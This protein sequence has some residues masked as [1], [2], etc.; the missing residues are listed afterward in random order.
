[1]FFNYPNFEPEFG[2]L[3]QKIRDE[4]I[5]DNIQNN[6]MPRESKEIKKIT[7]LIASNNSSDKLYFWQLYSILGELPIKN[8]ITVFYKRVLND[9]KNPWF[10]DEFIE[11]GNLEYHVKGQMNFWID[12]MGGGKKYYKTERVLYLKHQQVNEIMTQR[13]AD[14]WMKHMVNSLYE[15]NLCRSDD[16][17]IIPCIS[18]FLYY[19]MNKYAKEFDFNIYEIN[20]K[21]NL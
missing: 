21:S 9:S 13:G 1:M 20:I 15:V 12:I 7:S 19:F 10:R 17:R 18:D 11:I 3:T 2:N 6:S 8:L 5:E 16:K 14:L 4:Y